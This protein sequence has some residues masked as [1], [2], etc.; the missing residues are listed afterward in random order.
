MR[1]PLCQRRRFRMEER[2][3]EFSQC[4]T[5]MVPGGRRAHKRSA[6]VVGRTFPAEDVLRLFCSHF[7]SSRLGFKCWA[8]AA[9]IGEQRDSRVAG[10]VVHP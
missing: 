9:L 8:C 4:M 6:P 10:S 5:G 2:H 7:G 1:L 3:A